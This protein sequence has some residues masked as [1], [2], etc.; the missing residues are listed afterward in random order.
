M[1]YKLKEVTIRANNTDEGM[2]KIAELWQDI[3]D[4][5]L[6][7]LFDS[8]HIFQQGIMPISRYSSY[9][10]GENGEYDLSIMGVETDFI[11]RLEAEAKKGLYKKYNE[12]DETG[13]I[14]ACTIRAWEKVWGDRKSGAIKRAF[15][16][17]YEST[18]PA[19]YAK[20]GKAHCTLYIAVK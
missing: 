3:T 4:G 10:G 5:K 6:P 19:E 2:G 14:D 13:D 7:V 8:A 18:M 1:A 9:A 12:T 15:T 20:D 16:E 17:D 11:Q